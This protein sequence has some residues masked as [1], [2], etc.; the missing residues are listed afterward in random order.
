M[1]TYEVLARRLVPTSLGPFFLNWRSR[2]ERRRLSTVDFPEGIAV[3]AQG[4]C[5][6]FLMTRTPVAGELFIDVGSHI[7]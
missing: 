4:C 1:S 2:Q 5:N 7:G 6:R 3:A